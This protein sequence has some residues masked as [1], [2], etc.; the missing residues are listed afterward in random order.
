MIKKSFLMKIFLLLVAFSLCI[1]CGF[2]Q[3]VGK[4]TYI[5]GR[6]DIFKAGSDTGVPARDYENISVGDSIRTKSN[7]KAEITFGDNSLVR[8]AQNSKVEI[9]NY[10]L[11][12]KNKRKKAA[13]KLERGKIRTIVAKMQEPAEFAI[14]TPNSEGKITG[15]DI[16]TFYQAGSSG[17]LVAEGKMAVTSAAHLENPIMVDAGSSALVSLESLPQGPRPF[18]DIEKKIHEQ[19]TDIPVSIAK[20]KDLTVVTASIAKF[21]GEVKVTNKDE[22]KAHNAK[23]G[24]VVKEGDLIETGKTGLVEIRLDNNNAVNMKPDSKLLIVKLLVNPASGEYE[25]IFELTIGKIKARIEGLTGKSKFEMKTPLAICGAR[26]TILYVNSSTGS[27][28]SFIE[29]GSGYMTSTISGNTQDI[30]GGQGSSADGQGGVSGPAPLSQDQRQEFTE[31]WNT[32]SGVEGYSS[33]EGSAGYYFYDSNT[34]TDTAGEVS[35]LFDP[36]GIN[37]DGNA[38]Q[39]FVSVPITE[40]HSNILGGSET[41]SITTDVD[42]ERDK[43]PGE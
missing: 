10:E 39:N 27:T 25:N 22:A 33:L 20:S 31:G 41:G 3:E 18:L 32:E 14:L 36:E 34:G 1:P 13:L 30:P 9:K 4:V 8:L 11:S 38:L 12:E 19:D 23:I 42:T 7:S 5:E 17:M 28:D 15:S 35:Q 37:L 24:E 16:F 21:S 29:G 43:S 2:A 40:V 6:V 26:G